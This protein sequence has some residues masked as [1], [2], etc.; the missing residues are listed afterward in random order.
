MGGSVEVIGCRE[1]FIKASSRENPTLA[2]GISPL[3]SFLMVISRMCKQ[4]G[5]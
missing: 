1:S 5:V 4:S 2:M 3:T